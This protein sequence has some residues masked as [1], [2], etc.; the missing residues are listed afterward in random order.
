MYVLN[1]YV[2]D[3][4]RTYVLTMSYRAVMCLLCVFWTVQTQ[5]MGQRYGT[6]GTGK[7]IFKK[8]S[9]RAWNFHVSKVPPRQW[10]QCVSDFCL[11]LINVKI[12]PVV[13]P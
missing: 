3:V 10:S 1:V 4:R 12:T 11:V 5:G 6:V 2:P 9:L 7:N 13:R 8:I